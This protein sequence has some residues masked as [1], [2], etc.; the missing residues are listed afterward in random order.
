M[1]CI[2]SGVGKCEYVIGLKMWIVGL[3]VV[4]LYTVQSLMHTYLFRVGEYAGN[5]LQAMLNCAVK[6]SMDNSPSCFI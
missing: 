3:P 2:G 6:E 5:Y 1:D 4:Q